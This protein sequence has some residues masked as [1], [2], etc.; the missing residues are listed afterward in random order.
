MAPLS[1][2]A[3]ESPLN[4]FKDISSLSSDEELTLRFEFKRPVSGSGKPIFSGKSVQMDFR[5]VLIQPA[6]RFFYTSDSLIPQVYVYQAGPNVVRVRLALGEKAPDLE[7]RFAS[8]SE[9]RF[10][11]VRIQK[12]KSAAE[13]DI[14]GQLLARASRNLEAERQG[15]NESVHVG[16]A[17]LNLLTEPGTEPRKKTLSRMALTKKPERKSLQTIAAL[18]KKRVESKP[19][20]F[21]KVGDEKISEPLQLFPS[22]LRMITMLSL[23]VGLMFVLF[24]LFKK[25]VLKN[26]PFGGS[27]K[28]V[29]VLGTGFLGPKKNI[30]LVE[31]AGEVLVLGVSEDNISLLTNIQDPEQI[32]RIKNPGAEKTAPPAS[33]AT[34]TQKPELARGNPRSAAKF[35][36][37]LRESTRQLT[38]K[39]KS[40]AE[41]SAQ[42][43][44]NLRKIKTQ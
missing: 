27:G 19:P 13:P 30:A 24:Y 32:E 6:K 44:R 15:R 7:Q 11:V 34:R 36:N 42:I 2:G 4:F 31:V 40:M 14:L 43:R 28:L 38:P 1:T 21:P 26:T 35:S 16:R 20:A 22:S 29:Q 37:Y 41:V 12:Q 25:F 3:Q 18:E 8:E 33:A 23:V 39:E 17:A 5:N 9:G 10:L